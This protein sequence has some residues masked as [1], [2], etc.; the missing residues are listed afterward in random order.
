MGVGEHQAQVMF[1]LNGFAGSSAL[2]CHASVA[3]RSFSAQT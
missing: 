1:T 3:L 2:P